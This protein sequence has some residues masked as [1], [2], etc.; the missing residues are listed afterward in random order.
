MGIISGFP[1]LQNSFLRQAPVLQFQNLTH[2]YALYII[3]LRRHFC[4]PL[5]HLSYRL[6]K[7]LCLESNSTSFLYGLPWPLWGE[8]LQIFRH[9]E[10]SLLSLSVHLSSLFLS[11]HSLTDS[12]QFCEL[13]LSQPSNFV[14]CTNHSNLT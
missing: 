3:A 8:W 11:I 10:N 7:L 12:C 14:F 1:I 5:L 9:S 2:L 6:L 13:Y 4:M